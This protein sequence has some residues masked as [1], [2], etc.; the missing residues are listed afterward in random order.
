MQRCGDRESGKGGGKTVATRAEGIDNGPIIS[1]RRRL[2]RHAPN[3]VEGNAFR[4][5]TL[6]ETELLLRNI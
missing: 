2:S 5:E 1:G 6:R 3:S 4:K